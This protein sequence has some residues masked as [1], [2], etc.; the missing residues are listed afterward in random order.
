MTRAIKPACLALAGL[1]I[2]CNADSGE[3]DDQPAPDAPVVCG[4]DIVLAD[5]QVRTTGGVVEGA[6][7]GA[8]VS[9]KGIPFA[10][11][12]VG[13]L[14][15][16]PPQPPACREGVSPA[17]T[18]GAPCPQNL[19]G[20]LVGNEDCLTLNVWAP[21]VA[22]SAVRPVMVFIHGGGHQQGSTS[23]LLD[24]GSV[25]LD[26]QRLAERSGAVVVTVEYRLGPLGFLAHPA[27]SAEGPEKSG[28]YGM[29]DQ[30]ESLRWVRDNIAGF[31]GDATRVM[32]FGESAG[33]VSTCR[34]LA[35]PLAKGLFSSATIESGACV[36]RTLA[37]AE[38]Q[39]TQVAQTVGCTDAA[40]LRTVSVAA[41]MAT[42]PAL[43]SET[44]RQT[45]DGVI[46]GY[47]LL[48]AP[49]DV[50]K[51]GDHNHVPVIIGTNTEEQ[52]RSVP[53]TMTQTEY[54]TAVAAFA[55]SSGAPGL[56]QALLAQ[57]PTSDYPSPR[58]AMVALLSDTKFNCSARKALRALTAAQDEPVYQYSFAKVPDSSTG[59]QRTLGAVHGI[60]LIYVFDAFS[61]T[62]GIKDKAVITAVASAW[63]A[64]ASGGNPNAGGGLPV[65]W[66]P[67]E[68][69]TESHLRFGDT[70]TRGDHYRTEQCE[71]INTIA[72]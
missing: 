50:I 58:A 17:V 1:L 39:G 57:Y 5:R 26:G 23:Q 65:T 32:V 56:T 7:A 61:S 20:V 64:L 33:G 52:G 48:A 21:S 44:A 47:A 10:A 69:T 11:P 59:A 72:P 9:F 28:N 41:L 30:I 34:L 19:D 29:L 54:E 2:S 18:F 24:N 35:S 43:E 68:L 42:V 22:T 25:L 53:L 4:A 66:A 8:T 71:F 51:A 12:P 36:A 3:V 45:Y 70:I 63:G 55:Q 60:E 13:E 27:L 67:Y 15:Y 6:P 31:G 62:A 40:C 38:T 46:D 16:R 37:Q 49:L 14:R